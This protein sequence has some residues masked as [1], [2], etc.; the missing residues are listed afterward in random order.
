LQKP[1]LHFALFVDKVK[2]AIFIAKFRS[3]KPA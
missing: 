2:S 1:R 3:Q